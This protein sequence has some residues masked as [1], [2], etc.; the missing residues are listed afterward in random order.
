MKSRG[1]EEGIRYPTRVGKCHRQ[2]R[3][4]TLNVIEF[5]LG[6]ALWEALTHFCLSSPGTRYA[7]LSE[8]WNAIRLGDNKVV[9]EAGFQNRSLSLF[10]SLGKHSSS[11]SS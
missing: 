5:S 6:Q 4:S 9:S 10:M 11:V 1:W 3:F 8:S 2:R 7:M